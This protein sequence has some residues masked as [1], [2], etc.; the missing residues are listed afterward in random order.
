MKHIFVID[1]DANIRQLILRYLEKEGY[2]VTTFENADHVFEAFIN[3]PDSKTYL[4]KT[5]ILSYWIEDYSNYLLKEKS[6]DYT[7][8]LNFK[9][10]D[11]VK[12]N[13]GFNV[14]SEQ[15]GL[16]FGIVLDKNNNVLMFKAF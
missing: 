15:G 13:L 8:V 14:G 16:H 3:N 9:R 5:D 6:F 1:D 7:K 2:K 12:I 11:V 10:G 4:K